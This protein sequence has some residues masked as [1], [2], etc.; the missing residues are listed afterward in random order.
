[1]LKLISREKQSSMSPVL[2]Y[3]E[4]KYFPESLSLVRNKIK[5]RLNQFF[6]II[7]QLKIKKSLNGKVFA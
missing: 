4:L 3:N 6:L 5:N 7:K 1:M 2:N